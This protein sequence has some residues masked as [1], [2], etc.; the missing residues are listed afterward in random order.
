MLPPPPP[1]TEVKKIAAPP[2]PLMVPALKTR[3]VVER[4]YATTVA[5]DH[6]AGIVDDGAAVR[7]D[8]GCAA[9]RQSRQ[10]AEIRHVDG[11]A[12]DGAGAGGLGAA[13]DRAEIGDVQGWRL[14]TRDATGVTTDHAGGVVG[15]GQIVDQYPGAAQ[16]RRRRDRAGIEDRRDIRPDARGIAGDRAAQIVS[17][18][19]GAGVHDVI[20]AVAAAA[21]RADQPE[22][23]DRAGAAPLDAKAA[24]DDAAGL[25]GQRQAPQS[26]DTGQVEDVVDSV[27]PT[28]AAGIVHGQRPIAIDAVYVTD[29]AA[30]LRRDGAEIVDGV[31][32]V[33]VDAGGRAGHRGAGLHVDRQ[34]VLRAVAIAGVDAGTLIEGRTAA[35]HRHV[36]PGGRRARRQGV[37]GRQH[38]ST[39]YR[40]RRCGQHRSSATQQCRR[41]DAT[42]MQRRYSHSRTHTLRPAAFGDQTAERKRTFRPAPWP[43]S[44]APRFLPGT[45]G[46]AE[47]LQN[48][49]LRSDP[50]FQRRVLNAQQN[51]ALS[52]F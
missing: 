6:A 29:A 2:F 16:A 41:S 5:A 23:D 37:V 35:G 52:P 7:V 9:A 46:S 33:D 11:V 34:A 20:D 24:L 28:D 25:V 18:G 38:D 47:R 12:S 32:V 21:H 39:D 10:R 36:R 4:G 3:R 40:Q 27:G 30:A 44:A 50:R 31:V 42:V 49:F 1:P 15:Q 51:P 14:V 13:G 43:F 19:Q 8:R 48:A 22:I 45:V 17:H 26:V